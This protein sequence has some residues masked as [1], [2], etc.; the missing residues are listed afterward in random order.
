MI[1]RRD[2]PSEVKLAE[3]RSRRATRYAT[4]DAVSAERAETFLR[5]LAEARLRQALTATASQRD[6]MTT[7]ISR[8]ADALV[9]AGAIDS[10]L[11]HAIVANFRQA[12]SSRSGTPTRPG[13]RPG[14]SGGRVPLALF[15][16]LQEQSSPASRGDG[17]KT[18]IQLIPVGRAISFGD[19]HHDGMYL[20]ALVTTPDSASFTAG[21]WTRDPAGGLRD[22]MLVFALAAVDDQGTDYQLSYNGSGTPEQSAGLYELAPAPPQG[23]QWLDVTAGSGRPAVRISLTAPPESVQAAIE[24]APLS[25]AELM[26]YRVADGLLAYWEP[27]RQIVSSRVTGLGDMVA[28]LEAAGALPAGSPVPGQLLALCDQLGVAGHG[29]AAAPR[30][31]LPET[32]SSVLA[33]QLRDDPGPA[34]GAAAAHA[35]FAVAL[36]E[37]DGVHYAVAGLHAGYGQTL[38]HVAAHGRAADRSARSPASWWLRDETGQWHATTLLSGNDSHLLMRVVPAINPATATT[39]ELLVDGRAARIRARLPVTWWSP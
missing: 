29:I 13:L 1:H 9:E 26:L 34:S 24:A 15:A 27:D 18:P 12:V 16:D 32:W 38:L 31:D 25:P 3:I 28:A 7:G 23:A 5:K 4:V 21:S 37:L 20:A 36:P 2:R 39:L 11:A 22:R 10:A 17:T 33:H 35:A 30:P 8:A 19:D 14:R 6:A